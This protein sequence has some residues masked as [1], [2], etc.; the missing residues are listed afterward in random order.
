MFEDQ[1]DKYGFPIRQYSIGQAAV[2]ALFLMAWTESQINIALETIDRISTRPI[3]SAPEPEPPADIAPACKRFYNQVTRS[4]GADLILKIAAISS[5]FRDHYQAA[6][7]W[8][9]SRK[10]RIT[11]DSIVT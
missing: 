2:Q 3:I 9:E 10:N 5:Y 4:G 11:Q 8:A 1:T 6:I 7:R